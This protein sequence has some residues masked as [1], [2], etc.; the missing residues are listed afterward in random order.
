[1]ARELCGKEFFEG[2]AF[3]CQ[4]AGEKALKAVLVSKKLFDHTHSCDRLLSV[5]EEHGLEVIGVR[6]E[7][8]RL[9]IHYIPSRY[10]NGVGGPP[11][12]FYDEE[13]LEDIIKAAETI[14]TWAKG[15]IGD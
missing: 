4:Q 10:P 6:T 2:A 13:I 5:L 15:M 1:M 3:H 8:R 9:D 7:A 11:E 14:I 12:N